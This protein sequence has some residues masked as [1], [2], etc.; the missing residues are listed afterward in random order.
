MMFK[1]LVFSYGN[2]T[3]FMVWILKKNIMKFISNLAS[4]ETARTSMLSM[5]L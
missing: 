2:V 3:L 5:A 4:L 1:A